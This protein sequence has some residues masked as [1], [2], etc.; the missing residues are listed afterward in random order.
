MND[1]QA[2]EIDAELFRLLIDQS[3]DVITLTTAEG[4]VLYE[5]PSVQA[6]LGYTPD[7]LL[8]QQVADYLHPEDR[9]RMVGSI[10]RIFE[11][12]DVRATEFRFRHKQGDWRRLEGYGRSIE[13][14]GR[15]LLVVNSRDVTE[16]NEQLRQIE[17]Q[18]DLFAKTFASSCSLKSVSSVGDGHLVDVN[19]AWTKTFGI[20]REE[21]IG[22]SA[23]DLGL[24][25]TSSEQ[26]ARLLAR[27]LNGEKV[28]SEIVHFRARDGEPRIVRLDGEIV[29]LD[30]ER[31]L[32]FSGID[33]TDEL[34]AQ[35]Q[36]RQSQKLEA[37][38]QLTGGVAHDFNNLLGVIMGH[39]E[40]LAD[41]H[42]ADPGDRQHLEPLMQA[43]ER[44][45]SLTRQLLAFARR[46]PLAPKTIRVDEHLEGL[47]TMLEASLR[48]SVEFEIVGAPGLW[49]CHADPGQLDSAL[50]NLVLNARDA[51]PDGGSIRIEA[52][53]RRVPAGEA[54]SDG[55]LAPGDYVALA[56]RDTGRG[57]EPDHL[58]HVF[59]PFFTTKEIGA[60]TGLGLSM[61]FG[62]AHQ[63]GGAVTIDSEPGRGTTVELCLPR[64]S[65]AV[66]ARSEHGAPV[67][68]A[69]GSES[70]LVLEDNDSLRRLL[71]R[72]LKRL[73]YEPLEARD[74][75][76]FRALLESGTGVDLL[77]SDI[78]LP[79]PR[80]GPE[81]ARA[82][83]EARAGTPVLF[84]SGNPD[85][86]PQQL[87]EQDRVL[88]KPFGMREFASAVR[89]SLGDRVD[90]AP[91]LAQ[92]PTWTA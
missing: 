62:F 81:L 50:L 9:A 6:V 64:S 32:L 4:I 57:I 67:A 26:R 69:A 36:L 70:V 48:D 63:S 43:C 84:I 47:R 61:V 12:D 35:E 85:W 11:T 58:R 74:E 24:W 86:N 22:R 39:A 88:T 56:V 60:G 51:M 25:G 71:S 21:A 7:E 3:L 65:E 79:G 1:A 8:G 15:R 30:G 76:A 19:D 68:R 45:A 90:P 89:E 31:C 87:G 5:S 42:A 33:L 10:G 17:R 20:P 54:G 40:M 91:P 46:Q 41:L 72:Q 13:H 83:R 75:A 66:E 44:A 2:L 52:R 29:D 28:T 73:G 92:E 53:N 14:A 55:D 38:G 23:T 59:E 77:V 34:R 27:L 80:S 49:N 37:L 78:N 18:R 16:R 82:L